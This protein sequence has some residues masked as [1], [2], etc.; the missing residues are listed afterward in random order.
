MGGVYAAHP[1]IASEKRV[2]LAWPAG[3]RANSPR[4]RHYRVIAAVLC[5]MIS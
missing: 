4:R 3:N 5:A 1:E 2:A